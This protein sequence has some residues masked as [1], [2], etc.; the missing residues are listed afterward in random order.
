MW[1]TAIPTGWVKSRERLSPKLSY[2]VIAEYHETRLGVSHISHWY[3]CPQAAN[4]LTWQLDKGLVA[5]LLDQICN[6]F[7]CNLISIMRNFVDLYIDAIH[8]SRSLFDGD[9]DFT[10]K[11]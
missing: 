5:F 3:P 4:R 8:I 9:K 2:T 1:C 11:Q 10:F 7:T 6:H